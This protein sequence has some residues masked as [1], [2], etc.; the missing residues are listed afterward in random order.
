MRP[1][2][3]HKSINSYTCT[4]N[5]WTPSE[6]KEVLRNKLSNYRH[7]AIGNHITF[8]V[9]PGDVTI[10]SNPRGPPLLSNEWPLHSG[11]R[12]LTLE[13]TDNRIGKAWSCG[14]LQKINGDLRRLKI[15][16]NVIQK[17]DLT[18]IGVERKDPPLLNSYDA[19]FGFIHPAGRGG[20]SAAKSSPQGSIFETTR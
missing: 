12:R 5:I 19:G 3:P 2:L 13:A 15:G 8:L 4:D 1:F 17:G 10:R 7:D 18:L 20:C 9:S 6:E 11:S 14:N 16:D